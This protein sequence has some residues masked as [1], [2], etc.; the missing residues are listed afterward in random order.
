MTFEAECQ[1]C[2]SRIAISYVRLGAAAWCGE[3]LRFTVPQIP[4]GASVPA[5]GWALTFTDFRQL[6]E[7]RPYRSEVAQLFGEW[8]GYR[9]VEYQQGTLILNSHHEAVDPL[10]LHLKIQG[11]EAM[12]TQLYN[13]AMKLWR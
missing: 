4:Q 11:S 12:Q 3:C 6:L 7:G 2:R 1:H 10:W 5:S 13:R 8:F 9:L